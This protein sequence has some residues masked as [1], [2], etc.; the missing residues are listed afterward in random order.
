[1]SGLD[2]HESANSHASIFGEGSAVAAAAFASPKR[3]TLAAHSSPHTPESSTQLLA[4]GGDVGA[5]NRRVHALQNQIQQ[6]KAERAADHVN[7]G[8]TFAHD[9]SNFP[10]FSA[11]ASA[12]GG[13]CAVRA[14]DWAW[15]DGRANASH[16]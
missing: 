14:V 2:G 3:T 12:F 8:R 10:L 9:F 5:L 16:A 1:M 7:S 11:R 15:C 4:D 6:L 13:L